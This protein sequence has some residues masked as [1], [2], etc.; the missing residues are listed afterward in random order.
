MGLSSLLR[1]ESDFLKGNFLILT[2]SW[3]I[4][5][6][7]Q[8]IPATYASLY[9]ISL[10]ANA[11][12]LSV[13]GFAGSMAIAVVQF[14]GGYLADKHGRR[15]LIVVMSYALALCTFFFIFAPNWQVIV[16]GMILQN[17]CLIYGPAI[18]AMLLDSLPP[19][20]RG[21]GY[22]LQ[23]VLTNLVLLPA[24]L[25]AQYLI[26]RFNFDTGMRVAYVI[27]LIAYLATATLR[28]RLKETLSPS[29]ENGHLEILEAF[30]EYPESVKQSLSVWSKVP[31]SAYYLFLSSTGINGLVVACQAYF[32]V[33]AISI[34]KIT[35]AQWA[36]VTA[37]MYLSIAIP[38]LLAGLRMDVVGRKRFLILGYLLYIP[39]MLLFVIANYYLALLAFFFYGLGNMLQAN[40]YQVLLGDLVP[41]RLRG[42]VTGCMQF[43]MYVV[44]AFLQLLVGFLY[45]Y[46]SPQLPFLLLAAAA[47][48]LCLLVVYRVS[49]PTVKED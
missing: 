31:R 34:L 44:Q 42:T 41:R 43:F 4:M 35:E 15:R 47:V 13:I 39:A 46:V 5:Y 32:V 49:E 14:P 37:F 20:S 9:Y 6:F 8:P 36:I 1:R 23:S 26:V 19:K 2:A 7:A 10:G 40:S 28:L 16:L 45:V 12:L 27:V 29:G 17:L 21:T 3:M 38:I 25:I 18:M 48:P 22:N 30:R 24:P 33:Y 11:F